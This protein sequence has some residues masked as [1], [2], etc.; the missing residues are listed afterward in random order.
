MEA[1]LRVIAHRSA[2]KSRIVIAYHRPALTLRLVSLFVGR[3]GGPLKSSYTP[4]HMRALLA[5][6]GFT[7][8]SDDDLPTIAAA[9]GV[10][11]ERMGRFVR[12]GRIVVADS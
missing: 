12:H 8:T 11:T 10:G 9:V 3:L 6:Y 2:R 1:S 5:R 7:V 4:A